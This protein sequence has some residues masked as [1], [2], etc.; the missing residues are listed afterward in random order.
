M[1]LLN[2]GSGADRP[3]APW[4]NLD[5]LHSILHHGSQEREQLDAQPNYVNHDLLSGPMPF[6]DATF[7]GIILSH[8]LEHFDCQAGLKLVQDCRRL[9][10]PGGT[11]VV[12]VPDASYFRSVYSDDQVPNW[13]RLFDTTDPKNTLPSFFVAALWFNEHRVILTEDAVW[14]YF[15]RAGFDPAQVARLREW[16]GGNAVVD[17]VWKQVNRLKFSVVMMGTK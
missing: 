10:V 12:S 11:L 9:L 13:P 15:V 16:G 7:D 14:A 17:E 4:I 1:R 5:N 8:V 2:C 6:G 3:P